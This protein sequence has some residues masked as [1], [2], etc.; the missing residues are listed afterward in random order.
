MSS[1][2]ERS[3]IPVGS[4]PNHVSPVPELEDLM[5]LIEMIRP[6]LLPQGQRLM[7]MPPSP[8]RQRMIDV[9]WRYLVES[10]PAPQP[11]R[12]SPVATMRSPEAPRQ[13]M[14]NE[15]PIFTPTPQN[16]NP[17]MSHPP[18]FTGYEDDAEELCVGCGEA[19]LASTLS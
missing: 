2:S 15:H 7:N 1:S 10:A 17:M 8:A 3:T 9:L 13:Q 16:A 4:G 11:P 12:Q 6:E 5:M 19:R 14:P 18:G